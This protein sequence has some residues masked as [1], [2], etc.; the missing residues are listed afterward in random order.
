S[1]QLTARDRSYLANLNGRPVRPPAGSCDGQGRWPAPL[2]IP[3]PRMA[4]HPSRSGQLC[5]AGTSLACCA[6]CPAGAAATDLKARMGP[7]RKSVPQ[8]IAPAPKMAAA[9]QNAVV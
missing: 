2:T 1:Y 6:A 9:T 4:F 3:D 7:E 5:T 8:I